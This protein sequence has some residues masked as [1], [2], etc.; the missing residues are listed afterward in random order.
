[1]NKNILTC[2]RLGEDKIIRNS[3]EKGTS[4][5]QPEE[6]SH[7]LSKIRKA[8]KGYVKLEIC[9]ETVMKPTFFDCLKLAVQRWMAMETFAAGERIYFKF[10]EDNSRSPA[11]SWLISTKA[12]HLTCRHSCR[13]RALVGIGQQ[14]SPWGNMVPAFLHSYAFTSWTASGR[15]SK[16]TA[17]QHPKRVFCPRQML[18][19]EFPPA[20]L[21]RIILKVCEVSGNQ[22]SWVIFE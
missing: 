6:D 15:K 21:E 11:D 12:P 16:S 2:E 10:N 20:W 1:M 19:I 9:S 22:S 13:C 4:W 7:W 5:W 14:L 3:L 8:R 18:P 17:L